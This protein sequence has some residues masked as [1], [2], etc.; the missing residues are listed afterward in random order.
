[1]YYSIQMKDTHFHQQNQAK[2]VNCAIN[3]HNLLLPYI[4]S[5]AATMATAYGQK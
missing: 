1:M 2:I 3:F 4:A 5:N